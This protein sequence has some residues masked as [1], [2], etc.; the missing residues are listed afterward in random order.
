V[1]VDG[2]R[3]PIDHQSLL[4]TFGSHYFL[5]FVDTP[6]QIRFERSRERFNTYERFLSADTHPVESKTDLL[7]PL[8]AV[9]IPGTVPG[10]E[11]ISELSRLVSSFRERIG[12]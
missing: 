8:A 5:I 10:E 4:A 7:R 3:H 1:A 12:L 9:T 2:L 11:L 6:L